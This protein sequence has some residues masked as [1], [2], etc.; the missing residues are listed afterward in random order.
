MKSIKLATTK[1]ATGKRN[2]KLIR[3]EGNIP[4]VYYIKGTDS[5]P[6]SASPKALKDLVYTNE[7]SMVELSIEGDNQVYDCF[8]KDV[9]F[10]PINSQVIHFDLL[11]VVQGQELTVEIPIV[12]LG[13]PIGVRQSGGILQHTMRGVVIS[14]L[15]KDL[16]NSIEIDVSQLNIGDSISLKDI[17]QPQFEFKAPEDSMIVNVA[18]SRVSAKDEE[19]EAEEKGE[20]EEE[21]GEE[22]EE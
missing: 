6:I 20:G 15:P 11:G 10:D 12:L 9:T 1:R 22:E 2:T 14:C 8:L 17:A 16:P 7:M 18:A 4:G 21:E 13:T 3:K 5:I 19:E